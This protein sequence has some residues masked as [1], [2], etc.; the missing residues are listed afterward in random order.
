M[1][2]G[3]KALYGALIGAGG[4]SGGGGGGS[5]STFKV[6]FVYYENHGDCLFAFEPGMTW[7]D[8]ILSGY[9]PFY[10]SY[11]GDFSNLIYLGSGAEAGHVVFY[12]GD[13]VTQYAIHDSNDNPVSV[14]DTILDSSEETYTVNYGS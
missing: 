1:N 14:N 6:T 9:I 13:G 5:V 11:E 8:Y 12:G 7:N 4:S 10:I 2:D 3:A